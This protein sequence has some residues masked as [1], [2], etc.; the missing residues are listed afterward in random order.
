MNQ[1][2]TRFCDE[3]PTKDYS[4]FRQPP[5][6]NKMAIFQDILSNNSNF[7]ISVHI[8]GLGSDV[9]LPRLGFKP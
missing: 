9:T 7:T 4:E 2:N 5:R 8:N 6:E 3:I 1:E